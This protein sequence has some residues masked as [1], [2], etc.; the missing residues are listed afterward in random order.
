MCVKVHGEGQLGMRENRHFWWTCVCVCVCVCTHVTLCLSVASENVQANSEKT[1]LFF[2][3][4]TPGSGAWLDG[5]I[6]HVSDGSE[7]SRIDA[8]I[9]QASRWMFDKHGPGIDGG[10]IT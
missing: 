9:Q 7:G 10:F 1:W 8:D 5:T 3:Q 6:S 2:N 4:K